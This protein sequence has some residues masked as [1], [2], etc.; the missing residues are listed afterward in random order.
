MP[1]LQLAESVLSLVT[2][3]E[4]AGTIAGDFA[5]SAP[6]HFWL[7]IGRVALSLLW[8]GLAVRPVRM[9]CLAVG[10]SA[11]PFVFFAPFC[12][13]CYASLIALAICMAELGWDTAWMV[14]PTFD[15]LVFSA[16]IPAPLLAGRW[17]ARR[18]NGYELSACLAVTILAAAVWSSACLILGD[19]V[20]LFMHEVEG[21]LPTLGCLAAALVSLYSG[22]IWTRLRPSQQFWFE[23]VPFGQRASTGQKMVDLMFLPLT[24]A[25]S[26]AALKL[27]SPAGPFSDLLVLLF[28]IACFA[29]GAFGRP[30]EWLRIRGRVRT[31]LGRV[32][33]LGV[34]AC[35][36]YL[37]APH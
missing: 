14:I 23:R 35:L 18:A 29:N 3:R 10:A 19:S 31:G 20:S 5:E 21:V 9:A 25:A 17:L 27:A 4:H 15:L 2:T 26:I 11:M 33:F 36:F 34:A 1:N 32:V 16:L 8:K 28:A 7:S 24:A 37:G 6:S 30:L 22:A 13:G 12:I